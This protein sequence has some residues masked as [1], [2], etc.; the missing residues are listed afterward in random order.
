MLKAQVVMKIVE[1]AIGVPNFRE[2]L[3]K[4]VDLARAP[5]TRTPAGA[6]VYPSLVSTRSVWLLLWR[7]VL[8]PGD[9]VCVVLQ[10]LG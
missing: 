3:A 10:A 9:G 7:V 2:V 5:T 6:I 8:L 4:L 1:R